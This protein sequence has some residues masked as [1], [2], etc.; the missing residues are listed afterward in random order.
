MAKENN[1]NKP[2]WPGAFQN[3]SILIIQREGIWPVLFCVSVVTTLV[4]SYWVTPDE[5]NPEIWSPVTSIYCVMGW[6]VSFAI[7]VFFK[8]RDH[9]QRLKYN[10]E[11]K[12]LSAERDKSQR[13]RGIEIESSDD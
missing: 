8:T 7:Y 9:R 13:R 2:N 1:P 12:R 5:Q 11:F 4:A 6:I 3:V 10:E